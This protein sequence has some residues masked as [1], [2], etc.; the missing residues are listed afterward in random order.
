VGVAPAAVGASS[1]PAATAEAEA[2][3][4]AA[5]TGCWW[6]DV[7]PLYQRR[8]NLSVSHSSH[9]IPEPLRAAWLSSF[10]QWKDAVVD[11]AIRQG[12]SVHRV[13][14]LEECAPAAFWDTVARRLEHAYPQFARV[15]EDLSLVYDTSDDEDEETKDEASGVECAH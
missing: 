3:V 15:P 14:Y 12:K 4:E 10:G 9:N 1:Q 6:R 2:T 5:A 13:Q 8:V 11:D 7:F